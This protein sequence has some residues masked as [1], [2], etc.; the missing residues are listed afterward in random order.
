[1]EKG[2]SIRSI[3]VELGVDE[4]TLRYRVKRRAAGTVDGRS[5]QA[6][7]CAAHDAVIRE[8]IARQD[9]EGKTGRPE[10]IKSLYEL[11]VG[12][13]GYAGSYKA[14]QRYVRRRAP[15]PAVRPV[16]RVETRPGTQA[17]VDWGSRKV[18]VHEFGGVTPLKAFLMT[19]SHSRLSPVR[20]YVD[21]TQLSWLD[22]HNHALEFL[23]GIPLTGTALV[24][25]D[26]FLSHSLPWQCLILIVLFLEPHRALIAEFGVQSLLV[27][28]RDPGGSSSLNFLPGLPTA[29]VD[30]LRLIKTDGGF[31]QG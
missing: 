19:L 3:A 17:Q 12:E 2:R 16:R 22:G 24:L 25:V 21:E 23:G 15:T 4:S 20:F 31:H 10:S 30:D 1:M 29:P 7:A 18:F 8:W 5:S 26:G 11:L 6:E 9:W 13:Y 27:E 28:P 14:V